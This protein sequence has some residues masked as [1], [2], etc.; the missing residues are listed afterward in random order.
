[1]Y[2]CSYPTLTKVFTLFK[3]LNSGVIIMANVKFGGRVWG[4]VSGVGP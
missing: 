2:E 1:M 4:C 3:S